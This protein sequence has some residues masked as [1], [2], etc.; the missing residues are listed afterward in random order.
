MNITS[1]MEIVTNEWYLLQHVKFY[2][3]LILQIL[4]ISL[5]LL[6]FTFFILHPTVLRKLQHKATLVLLIL[7][8]TQLTLNLPLALHFYLLGRVSPATSAYCKWWIF[9]ESTLDAVNEFLAATISLQRHI[10]VFKPNMLNVRLTR[11]LLYYL[12]LLFS[13]IYPT[14][15]YMATVLFYPCDDT[16]W[17]FT[18]ITCGTTACYLSGNNNLATYDWIVDTALPSIVILLSDIVLVI[19]VT[20]QRYRRRQAITWSKQRRM[21]LQL[22]SISSIYLVT[23]LPNIV[24]GILQQFYPSAFLNVIEKNYVG[25]LTYLICLLIPW[26]CIGLLPE[27]TKWMLNQFRRLKRQWNMVRPI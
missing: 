2:I 26:I 12:P 22:L 16:Q 3:I 10:L 11:Y 13:V 8:F 27:F 20:K 14:T 6:I 5:C 7:N 25:D 9:I 17:D 19:R 1:E 21:T 23:W 15:F 4:S 24:I 18:A